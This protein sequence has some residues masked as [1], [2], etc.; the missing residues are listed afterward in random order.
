[1]ARNVYF[2]TLQAK[3][4]NYYVLLFEKNKFNMKATWKVF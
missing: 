2:H 1:M 4:S 3:K